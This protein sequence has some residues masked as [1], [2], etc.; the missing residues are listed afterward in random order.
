ML[1]FLNQALIKTSKTVVGL[2]AFL[3]VLVVGLMDYYTGLEL[4]FSIF[5]LAPIAAAAWYG[6]KR[7][8][9]FISAVPRPPGCLPISRWER[10]TCNL[11]S[12]FGAHS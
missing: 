10:S 1:I 9:L 2:A 12:R 5:Y 7:L 4:S 3:V 11:P 8:G 6:G